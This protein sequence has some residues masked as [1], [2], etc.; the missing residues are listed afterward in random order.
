MYGVG[1]VDRSESEI[2]AVMLLA[3]LAWPNLAVLSSVAG[4]TRPD[5]PVW[6]G[7]AAGQS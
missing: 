4:Q 6:S 5:S 1:G 3:T 2:S 7:V